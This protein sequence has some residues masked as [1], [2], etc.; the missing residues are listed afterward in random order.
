M[1]TRS[2]Q[3]VHF[4]ETCS[5]AVTPGAVP[6]HGLSASGDSPRQPL[7]HSDEPA[8]GIHGVNALH[9]MPGLANETNV[10]EALKPSTR[11]LLT[12]VRQ[13]DNGPWTNA[14]WSIHRSSSSQS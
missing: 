13:I 7:M 11:A 8:G 9:G 12:Q 3:C 4:V 1:F 2:S 5:A 14:L 6:Y 10:A